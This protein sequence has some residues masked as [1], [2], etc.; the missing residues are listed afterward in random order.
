M[1]RL[2]EIDRVIADEQ[3]KEDSYS[4]Q[5]QRIRSDPNLDG[6]GKERKIRELQ[7]RT[8]GDEADAFRRR[9]AIERGL[10]QAGK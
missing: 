7:D 9:Q 6:D 10:E 8:F 3:K 2:D 1:K 5:E 4:A